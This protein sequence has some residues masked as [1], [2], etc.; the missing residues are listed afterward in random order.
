MGFRSF[1]SSSSQSTGVPSFRP[2]HR[3]ASDSSSPRADP[4][5]RTA[6]ADACRIEDEV[7][8]GGPCVRESRHGVHVDD[9]PR[10][11][12]RGPVE[13]R[14]TS[15]RRE[16]RPPVAQVSVR[17]WAGARAAAGTDEERLVAGSTADVVAALTGRGGELARVVAL[18]S[19]L[20]DGRVVRESVALT[21][22]QVVEV[23]PPFAGG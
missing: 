5:G 11:R 23:L 10:I 7:P 19:L 1:V 4:G 18:S 14:R 12:C 13:G 3:P 17:Y 20:V 8:I 16:R 2:S 9:T 22:G 21:E 6:A 15:R